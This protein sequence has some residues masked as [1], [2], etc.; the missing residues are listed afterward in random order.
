M[1]DD[2]EKMG[3]LLKWINRGLATRIWDPDDHMALTQARDHLVYRINR[4][5]MD[6]LAVDMYRMWGESTDRPI[7]GE[8]RQRHHHIPEVPALSVNTE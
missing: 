5:R 4:G 1:S 2:L 3:R 7:L 8:T 6:R